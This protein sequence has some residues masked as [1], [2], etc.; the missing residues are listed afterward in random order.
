VDRD[1]AVARLRA[2]RVGRL[3]TVTPDSRPHVVPFVFVVVEDERSLRLYWVVD[4]KPKRS[5][6]LQRLRNIEGNPA[7]EVVVDAYDEDW[8]LLWWVRAAGVG[9]VVR[10]AKEREAALAALRTRFQQ[11]AI[12]PPAGPVVAIDVERVTGWEAEPGST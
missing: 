9:R 4:R 1:E 3:A 2:A 8:R 7:V 10:A 5:R 6:R 11:Y 12:A